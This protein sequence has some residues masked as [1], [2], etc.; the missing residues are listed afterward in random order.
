MKNFWTKLGKKT[1]IIIVC[2]LI[3]AIAMAAT[4][5]LAYFTQMRRAVNVI[6][7]AR[8]DMILHDETTGG[9]DFPS[10]G[11]D[12]VM[13]GMSVDKIVY[14]ENNGTSDEYV[15][16]SLDKK[17]WDAEGNA[18]TLNYDHITLNINT[19]DWTEKDGWYYY[20]SPLAPGEETTKLFT[21][22]SFGP[23]LGN[24]YM[25]AR[26]EIDVNAEATQVEHNG[27]SALE[28]VF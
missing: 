10:E 16:I 14:I 25:E 22:V 8:L 28:A 12:G 17:I 1:R 2:A 13:P 9:E 5:T 4:G 6:S 21:L 20:N 23:E 7:M 18:N 15:R 11:I 27:A 3:C 26:L 19:S 24:E